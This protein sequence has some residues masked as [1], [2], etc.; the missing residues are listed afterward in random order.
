M[1][2]VPSPSVFNKKV[3][4]REDKRAM[5]KLPSHMHNVN[6]RMACSNILERTLRESKFQQ[7]DWMEPASQ[8]ANKKTFRHDPNGDPPAAFDPLNPPKKK[9]TF[10]QLL[11]KF[12]YITADKTKENRKRPWHV[13][14]VNPGGYSSSSDEEDRGI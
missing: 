10:T 8:I 4:T 14:P 1:A 9:M 6:N 13:A 11:T 5:R 7:A 2:R 3:I 12:G